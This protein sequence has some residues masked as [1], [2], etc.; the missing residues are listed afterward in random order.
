MI[1]ETFKEWERVR[2]FLLPAL[3][4]CGGTH[5]E[6]DVIVGILQGQYRI[7]A[8]DKSAHLTETKQFP[9][10]KVCNIFLAGGDKTELLEKE[11]IIAKWA[12]SQGCERMHMGGRIGWEK[13]LP[14]IGYQKIG[15]LMMK[16]I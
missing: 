9:R 14:E 12:R 8:W 15:I 6:D 3:E 2:G 11:A 4:Y 5:N 16:D 7:W 10:L 1:F 13:V